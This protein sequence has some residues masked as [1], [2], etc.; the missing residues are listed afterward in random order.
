MPGDGRLETVEN[1]GFPGFGKV[2]GFAGKHLFA[3]VRGNRR[4]PINPRS[5]LSYYI[6][7]KDAE[8]MQFGLTRI[9]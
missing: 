1:Q 9:P 2:A 6:S 3:F 4:K 7:K 5:F 8:R